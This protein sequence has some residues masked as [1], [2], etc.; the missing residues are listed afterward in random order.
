MRMLSV[1]I[2]AC[3]FACLAPAVVGCDDTRGA[4]GGMMDASVQPD[5]GTDA[6]SD[7]GTGRIDPLSI[8][9]FV[10][11]L[12]VPAVMPPS[13]RSGQRVEYVIVARQ[14]MQQILPEGMPSTT[15]WA[16]GPEN[17][18]ALS[19]T[20]A[21]TIEVR[22]GETT[23]IT[24]INGLV[25]AS[26]AFLPHLLPVDQTIHWA[27]PPGP[28]DREGTD[29]TPYRG[30][31]PHVTHLHGGHSESVS[32][33]LPDAWYLPAA[34]NI[35]P[36]Y[37]TRGSYYGSVVPA[38]AGAAVFEYAHNHRAATLWYHDHVLGMTR[39]NVYAGLA[40]YMLRR[41]NVEDALNLPGPAPA[42]GDAPG[43]R[44]Y[45]IPIAIQDRSFHSDG[46]LYY[47]ATRAEYDGFSGPYSP[48]TEVPPIWGPEHFGDVMVVN[49]QSWPYLDVEPRLYRFRLLNGCNSR[50][51]ILRLDK[52]G[53]TF[54]QIGGEGGL[55][56]DAPV[57]HNELLMAPGQR[58]DV[59]V[60]FSSLSVGDTVVLRNLG[61]D[62]PF[63]STDEVTPADPATTGRVMQFRVVAPTDQ[64]NPGTIPT[65][66]PAIEP[67]STDLAPRDL[68]LNERIY[69]PA[70]VPYEAELGTV[71]LGALGW[72]DPITEELQEKDTEIWRL[73]NLTADAHPIHLHLVFF[74]VI[75]RTPFDVEAFI[76]AQEAHRAGTGPLPRIEDFVTGPA[77]SAE[78]HE[79][80]W[81]DTAIARPGEVTRIIATF[82]M[83][84]RY[85]WHCHI[86]EH[87]DNEMMRPYI[88]RPRR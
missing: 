54:H 76:T 80:G 83:A 48:A 40:G 70:D 50:F 46:S 24:W 42:L 58:A 29:P 63:R 7:A 71:A 86:L 69:T 85:V 16:Y 62:E 47:P 36:D 78:P 59:I 20:P 17:A 11:P 4:D 30:P 12:L 74:Q 1:R 44:Y 28:I 34:N 82:D 52:D 5:A 41:D 27:N 68:T 2:M 39:L 55:L 37:A 45:E 14:I 32:D 21:R 13:D 33:G 60:D 88:V 23:R 79:R 66:L 22:T 75:D 57:V 9:Q 73:I 43:T 81:T 56:P 31:V 3:A 8:P 35:P 51:L 64:G 72:D 18:V 87:E 49:G 65:V 53:L 38:P 84:G 6:G 15:V 25:D 19:Q 67:L 10:A 26:G 61:P 77:V